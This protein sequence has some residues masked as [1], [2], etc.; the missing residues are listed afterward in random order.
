M[1]SSLIENYN[2]HCTLNSERFAM[3][4]NFIWYLAGLLF[5]T[6][7]F[8]YCVF[9]W[10]FIISLFDFYRPAVWGWLGGDVQ[11]ASGCEARGFPIFEAHKFHRFQC[12]NPPIGGYS[13]YISSYSGSQG[14]VI[15]GFFWRDSMT[16]H[17][18]SALKTI[19]GLDYCD[20]ILSPNSSSFEDSGKHKEKQR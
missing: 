11:Q 15:V 14:S 7:D 9:L 20:V 18:I 10:H 13:E 6:A 3:V 2:F 19:L 1:S 16:T 5:I 12:Q 4:T 8:I 17:P